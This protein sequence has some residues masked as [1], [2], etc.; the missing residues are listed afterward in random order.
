[1]GDFASFQIIDFRDPV[2]SFIEINSLSNF[3]NKANE[4]DLVHVHGSTI[5]ALF[6]RFTATPPFC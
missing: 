5:P 4:Y 2:I 1:M 3:F 6:S